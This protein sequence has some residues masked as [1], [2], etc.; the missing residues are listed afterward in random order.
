MN[1]THL[2]DVDI[3]W[4]LLDPC[5]HPQCAKSHPFI[6]TSLYSLILTLPYSLA[7][8]LHLPTASSLNTCATVIP[9]L[10]KIFTSFP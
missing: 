2:F 3:L 1:Y 4:Q 9:P 5:G 10:W 6:R 7:V 8:Q